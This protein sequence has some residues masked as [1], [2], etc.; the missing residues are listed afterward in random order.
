MDTSESPE[1]KDESFYFKL[2][3]LPPEIFLHIC[4]FLSAK[5]VINVL[6]QVCEKF[7]DII[8]NESTW[9]MRIFES[10]PNR[11]P[12][13][14][15]PADFD[16]KEACIERE[17][18]YDLWKNKAENMHLYHLKD[19]HFGSVN[20][21]SL[22]EEGSMCASG[23][24]DGALKLWSIS[25]LEEETNP[26]DYLSCLINSTTGAHGSAWLWSLTY[27]KSN[28]TLYSG[29]FDCNIKTW[30]LENPSVVLSTH[31]LSSPILCLAYSDNNLT[32]GCYGRSVSL[33]D[34]RTNL[35]PVWQHIHHQ[36]PV[37][38]IVNDDKHVISGSED[39]SIIV[40]D[41]SARKVLKTINLEGFPL[42]MSYEYG[43]LLVGDVLGSI[44]VIDP[45]SGNFDLLKS[46][47]SGHKT[48]ITGIQHSLGSVMTCSTDKT[49]RV[50]EPSENPSIITVLNVGSE[51][52]KISAYKTTLAS[53]NTDDSISI[54][55]P[56]EEEEL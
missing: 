43:Q 24:R 14:P 21:V 34:P 30:D 32:S 19:A 6:S 8:E 44:H 46:Y 27:D 4:S 45:V 13:V 42:S 47:E 49:I 52:S 18:H 3:T 29:G 28:K 26:R 50:L 35:Q 36:R 55:L 31:S 37:I 22:L 56:K 48:K 40:Y 7:R 9:R 20:V 17:D 11:Y 39:K 38:C 1:D 53:A 12:L 54:W 33:F 41:K 25:S 23:G 51:V 16:W 15:A 10:W 2:D 5:Y